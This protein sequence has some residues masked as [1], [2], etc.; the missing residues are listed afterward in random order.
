MTA[1]ALFFNTTHFFVIR[2][3]FPVSEGHTLV[4]PKKHRA[5][6]FSLRANEWSDLPA[7]IR[8]VKARLDK[9]L[10]PD[11][12]NIAINCGAAAGQTIFHLHIHVIPRY[13]RDTKKPRA[14]R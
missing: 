6:I 9:E 11:G 10:K 3:G 8:R 1:V 2:D 5:D 13:T 4:I 14:V 12:Y 7:T